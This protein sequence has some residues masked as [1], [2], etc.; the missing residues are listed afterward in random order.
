MT[1]KNEGL[2]ILRFLYRERKTMLLV[3]FAAGLVSVIY[4]AF[5][6]P[7]YRATAT[8]FPPGFNSADRMMEN[9]QFGYNIEADRMIQIGE[10][11]NLKDSLITA[12]DLAEYYGVDS[13][14]P[15]W[16]STLLRQYEK[17][18]SLERTKYM[19]VKISVL[20]RD[21]DKA[22]E[23][24]NEIIALLSRF[25]ERLFKNNML[26]SLNY[27]QR[28]YLN[29]Q[30]EVS[31]ILDSIHDIRSRNYDET[32]EIMRDQKQTKEKEVKNNLAEMGKL[33]ES[34]NF[35]NYGNQMEILSED[36]VRINGVIEIEKAKLASLEEAKSKNDS[37]ISMVRGRY[38]G[39]LAHRD[40]LEKE[41]ASLKNVG[42]TYQ[43]VSED[44]DKSLEQYHAINAEYEGLLF[45]FEPLIESVDLD[46]LEARYVHERN[47]LNELKKKYEVAHRYYNEP[48]PNLFVIENARP[49]YKRAS[50]SYA[51]NFLFSTLAAFVLALTVLLSKRSLDQLRKTMPN[52]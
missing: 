26:E 40:Y 37:A 7:K 4:T 52:E 20:N 13:T 9:P 39:A 18:I 22:A 43:Q 21:P 38:K 8:V 48:L 50:P 46:Y 15:D 1:E 36:L 35:Y 34:S 6:T 10:S 49:I 25:W 11:V 27:A 23:M 47:A 14:D 31:A 2:E 32:L 42:R 45:S 29:K 3:V 44:L 5:I 51:V 30:M 24:V 41:I 16:K 33:R 12:F 17:D 19:S 28:M